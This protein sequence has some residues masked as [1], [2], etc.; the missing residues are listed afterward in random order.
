MLII[1]AR[2]LIIY[3][4][5]TKQ[6]LLCIFPE[7]TESQFS[8]FQRCPHRGLCE[9][10]HQFFRWFCGVLRHGLH[11]C[12]TKHFRQSGRQSGARPCLSGLSL[13]HLADVGIT[14]LGSAVLPHDLLC[15][16]RQSGETQ[17]H[18]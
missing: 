5:Y 13:S 14:N 11:G 8:H 18:F 16:T 10:R 6:L 4:W 17:R 7:A 9:Q 1:C 15:R 2:I 3:M 12:K